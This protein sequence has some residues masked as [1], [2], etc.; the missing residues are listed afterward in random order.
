MSTWVILRSPAHLVEKPTGLFEIIH[1]SGVYFASPE[2]HIRDLHITPICQVSL[3]GECSYQAE[4]THSGSRCT[5]Y[6]H[7]LK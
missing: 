5:S 4:F 1:V 6:L 7:R 2:L 3:A